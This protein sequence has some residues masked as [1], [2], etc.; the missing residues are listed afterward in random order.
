VGRLELAQEIA[1]AD[2]I[3]AFVNHGA[4]PLDV[5]VFE[6]KERAQHLQRV[7]QNE[8][9]QRRRIGDDEAIPPAYR[10]AR[11]ASRIA[12]RPRSRATTFRPFI[13]AIGG[14]SP[15]SPNAAS[16]WI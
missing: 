12:R 10:C 15:R 8:G 9:E 4:P 16:T 13:G 11:N 2:Q 6:Q 1:G 3:D 7:R 14:R 5:A